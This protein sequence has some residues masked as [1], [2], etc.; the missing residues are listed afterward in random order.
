MQAVDSRA[1]AHRRD[2]DDAG[3][4]HAAGC[5][6]HAGARG[7]HNVASRTRWCDR[8]DPAFAPKLQYNLRARYDWSVYDYNSL[9]R[10]G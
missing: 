2:S 8:F 6:H 3:Q 7:D 5:V 10:W 9:S 1:F 4:S